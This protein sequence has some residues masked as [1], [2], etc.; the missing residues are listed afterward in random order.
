MAEVDGQLHYHLGHEDALIVH[1]RKGLGEEV[2]INFKA[3]V[4][5]LAPKTISMY[6]LL[7][8]KVNDISGYKPMIVTPTCRLLTLLLWLCHNIFCSTV[9]S[10]SIVHLLRITEWLIVSHNDQFG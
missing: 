3:F 10:P 1:Y 8:T 4:Q 6:L 9:L 7:V 5:F 2:I